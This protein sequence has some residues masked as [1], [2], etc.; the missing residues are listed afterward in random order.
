MKIF[1]ISL[2]IL[3]FSVSLLYQ[4]TLMMHIK[5]IKSEGSYFI[6]YGKAGSF[7]IKQGLDVLIP[8]LKEEYKKEKESLK[9]E[10][11]DEI[12]N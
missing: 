7:S 10:D 6:E 3:L 12:R 8:F 11:E 9:K 4:D 1:T 2:F 5:I